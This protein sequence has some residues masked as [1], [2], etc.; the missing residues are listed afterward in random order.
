MKYLHNSAAQSHGYL[1]S[2]NCVIDSRWLLKSL[3]M[4][5]TVDANEL[6]WFAPELLRNNH[7]FWSGSQE[8]DVYSFAIIMQE[9]LVRDKPYS[10]FAKHLSTMDIINRIMSESSDSAFR[11]QL[12]GLSDSVPKDIIQLVDRCWQERP[13]VRPTFNRISDE[14]VKFLGER[15]YVFIRDKSIVDSMLVKIEKYAN[16]LEDLVK[17][18]TIC[19]EEERRKTETLLYRMLPISVANNLRNGRQVLPE[20]YDNVTIFFSDIIGFTT[21][22]SFSEP[23]EVI[24]ILN[25]LYI[26]FDEIVQNFDVYK[27]ETIGDAYMVV[28][29]IPNRNED[30]SEQIASMALEILHFC[31][32]FKMRHMPT[33]PLRLRCGI[34]TVV[35]GVVG[36]TNP[37]YCLF[38]DTVNIASRLETT[39]QPYRIHI[40]KATEERL[41]RSG[42]YI[43]EYRGEITLKGRGKQPTYYLTGKRG[44]DRI[45]PVPTEDELML[46]LLY[47]SVF[48]SPPL[49][50]SSSL[51]S[52]SVLSSDPISTPASL[53]S[54]ISVLS[55]MFS[56][57]GTS[58]LTIL[59]ISEIWNR[60]KGDSFLLLS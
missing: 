38:G 44:F 34:H 18:R 55:M 4:D 51:S 5:D 53:S 49:P 36:N 30:H 26:A 59:L 12:D 50:L 56:C 23:L 35:G 41:K 52:L 27:I 16:N 15:N 45:L 17:E 28:S 2:E 22:A 1:N 19:L 29:G 32:Q 33:I 42:D 9:I 58:L 10:T 54:S 13:E 48:A 47:Y 14:F 60:W 46:L 20:K 31:L 6:L 3:E 21:I 25:D 37:R 7:L 8:A 11:P 24:T 40:S 57:L 43:I 39:S